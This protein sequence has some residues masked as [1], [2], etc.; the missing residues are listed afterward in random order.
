MQKALRSFA[1]SDRFLAEVANAASGKAQLKPG[2]VLLGDEAFF[3][4]RC[5]RAVVGA[6]VDPG[7][8]DFS[9][10]DIDLAEIS[11]FEA[12]DRARTPSLMAPFRRQN[13]LHPWL[14]EG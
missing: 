11:I 9:L 8:R 12:L 6:F 1:S 3:Y 13:A 5:R 10:S 7:L 14:K 2:Y 4:D